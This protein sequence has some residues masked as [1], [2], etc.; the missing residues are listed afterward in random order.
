MNVHFEDQDYEFDFDALDVTQARHLKRQLGLTLKQFQDGLADLD[1][2]CLVGL[3]WLM[4]HQNGKA[5]DMNKVNFNIAAFGEAFAKAGEEEQGN[6]TQ[7][8]SS[9]KPETSPKK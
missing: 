8:P 9:D 4:L 1:P 7:S 3:Y 5:V 2:D 6:P